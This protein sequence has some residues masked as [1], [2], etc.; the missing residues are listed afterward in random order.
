MES[1]MNLLRRSIINQHT[2]SYLI[3]VHEEKPTQKVYE[4]NTARRGQEF[5]KS[6]H[7]FRLQY[8]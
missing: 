8:A 4:V 3:W 2:A 7:N 5:V 1:I 6:D